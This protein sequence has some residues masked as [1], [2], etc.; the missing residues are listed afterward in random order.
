MAHSKELLKGSQILRS[1]NSPSPRG[2]GE[3]QDHGWEVE[4]TGRTFPVIEMS[5]QEALASV[6]CWTQTVLVG[7]DDLKSNSCL[8]R[9]E[10]GLI[11]DPQSCLHANQQ[12]APGKLLHSGWKQMLSFIAFVLP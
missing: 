7:K 8:P 5:K 1:L 12:G 9:A 4:R 10:P 6:A 11:T 2:N 3:C